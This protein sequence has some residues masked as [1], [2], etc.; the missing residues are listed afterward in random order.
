MVGLGHRQLHRRHGRTGPHPRRGRRRGEATRATQLPDGAA[1][2]GVALR[3]LTHSGADVGWLWVS[4]GQLPRP[5]V[6]A[7]VFDVEVAEE[8]RGEGHGRALM[9]VAERECSDAGLRLLG[10]NVFADNPRAERLY[11]S[12]G[13][14]TV[15][16]FF[17][18]IL[19]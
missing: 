19:L 18:K 14:R 15:E 5:D 2:D 10:L 4:F 9:L 1:T 17:D 6:E 7:W 13:Y 8:R 3:V 11:I 12:L 16:R